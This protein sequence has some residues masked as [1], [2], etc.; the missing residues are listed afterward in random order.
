[1]ALLLSSGVTLAIGGGM[2]YPRETPTREVKELNGL[3][4]FRADTSPG[5]NDGFD[6][7]W[8]KSP[9]WQVRHELPTA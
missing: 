1:M 3:W 2:L 5:R 7:Q 6:R 9:L 4:S 8:Y